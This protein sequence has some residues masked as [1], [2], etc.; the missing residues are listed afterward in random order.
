[1]CLGGGRRKKEDIINPGVGIYLNKKIGEYVEKG[2]AIATVYAD[3]MEKAKES[4][5]IIEKAY[6][7]T[8]DKTENTRDVIISI[9]E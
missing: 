2:Q 5:A 6:T 8:K 1:M 7:V 9:I 4:L 3:D